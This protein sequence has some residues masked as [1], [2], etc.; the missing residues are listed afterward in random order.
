MTE[1]QAG[2][3]RHAEAVQPG[4]NSVDRVVA[5][6]APGAEDNAPD[7]VEPARPEQLRQQV[8]EPVGGLGDVLEQGDAAAGG[9]RLRRTDRAGQHRERSADRDTGGPSP[10]DGAGAGAAQLL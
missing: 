2:E 6:V 8:V 10:G 5:A 1:R 4:A 3:Q 9:P 7:A